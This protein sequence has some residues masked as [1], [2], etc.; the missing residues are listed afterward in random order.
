M[1]KVLAETPNKN[2]KDAAIISA[3]INALSDAVSKSDFDK[4]LERA[5]ALS[6]VQQ[7]FAAT[8]YPAVS[9]FN[10]FTARACS[11]GPRP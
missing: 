11:P 3:F 8:L 5:A 7:A 6:A 10:A 1:A 4:P 2:Q 9:K